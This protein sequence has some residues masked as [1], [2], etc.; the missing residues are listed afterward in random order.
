MLNSFFVEAVPACS[1]AFLTGAGVVYSGVSQYT[2]E[3]PVTGVAGGIMP[4]LL[5]TGTG[6]ACCWMLGT[7][8]LLGTVLATLLAAVGAGCGGGSSQLG[9]I[10]AHASENVGGLIVVVMRGRKVYELCLFSF[11]SGQPVILAIAVMAA[12]WLSGTSW[13]SGT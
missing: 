11:L 9:R 3:V 8:L 6:C 2:V 7:A 1:S 12:F 5:M 13:L 4:T 10:A